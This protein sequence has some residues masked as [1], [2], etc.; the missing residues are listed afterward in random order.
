MR[1][2]HEPNAQVC[3][4]VEGVPEF[5]ELFAKELVRNL[6]HHTRAISGFGVRVHRSAVGHVAFR[7]EPMSQD[8]IGSFTVDRGN[9]TDA[10]RIV[11]LFR[12]IEG[13]WKTVER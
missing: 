9:K 1:K 4:V 8:S 11:F 3:I 2:E 10:T 13:V 5:R 7:S 12:P 6:R